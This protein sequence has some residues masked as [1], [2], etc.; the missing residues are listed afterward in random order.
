MSPWHS[1]RK[2]ARSHPRVRWADRHALASRALLSCLC[3]SESLLVQLY[4]I[5]LTCPHADLQG[6]PATTPAFSPGTASRQKRAETPFPSGSSSHVPAAAKHR[7]WGPT[8]S[9]TRELRWEHCASIRSACVHVYI[10]GHVC[11]Q[12]ACVR[13]C[14]RAFV[15]VCAC[16]CMFACLYMTDTL[17]WSLKGETRAGGPGP[18]G[19]QASS[20][21]VSSS[22]HSVSTRGSSR[23]CPSREPWGN[24]D[25][26]K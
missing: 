4:L 13:V 2:H 19:S 15:H 12:P 18:R 7:H 3:T 25:K 26:L 10:H 11:M 5:W 6:P 17:L 23:Q 8:P 14:T 1:T 20:T 21:M 16:V 9:L 24:G 22:G